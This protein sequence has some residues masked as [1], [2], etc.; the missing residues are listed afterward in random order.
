MQVNFVL[1]S[2]TF[3]PAMSGGGDQ[4]VPATGSSNAAPFK[5]AAGDIETL[6]ADNAR[7]NS[8]LR[9]AGLVLII[10]AGA[11]GT[12]L[13]GEIAHIHP[14]KT[15][16]LVA[17]GPALFPG[18]PARLG[19]SLHT[20]LQAMGVKV[21]AGARAQTLPGQNTPEGGTVMLSE[22]REIEAELIV[23]AVGSHAFPSLAETLPD[24]ERLADGR[25]KA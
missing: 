1:M 5:S 25:I 15:A 24:M 4:I 2:R 3:K 11:V 9:D 22:G 19:T 12:E 7:W 10:G 13:A 18:F 21:F 20:R 17:R 16:K 23:P 14:E 8:A 6:R